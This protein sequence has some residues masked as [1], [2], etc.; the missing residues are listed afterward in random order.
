[1]AGGAV[2]TWTPERSAAGDRSPW[3]I[4]SIVSLATFME[5]LDT[6]IAN[7]AL[8][9]IA[10]GLSASYDEATWVVTSYLI[11]NAIAV[12]ISGWLS[13]VVG[14]KRFYM[15]SVIIFTFA[16][17]LCGIAPTLPFLIVARILQGLG[18][19]GL[20]PSEQSILTQTFPPAQRGQAYALY[21]L[22]VI[23]AP[24]LGPTLGGLITDN[25]G[26]HAIFLINIP[27][28]L[29]SLALVQ[30]FVVDP[31]KLEEERQ[32]RLKGGLRVDV[33]GIV[34]L[35]LWL[36]CQEFVLDRGQRLDW[37]D[38]PVI[39][40]AL[41]VSSCAAVGLWLWEWNHKDPVFDVRLLMHRSYAIAIAVMMVTGLV[42]FGILQVIP[43]FLQ[44]GLGYTASNAGKAM[45]LGGLVTVLMMSPAGML[46]SKVQPK[47]LI[48]FGLASEAIGLYMFTG[49]N[50]E[51]SFWWM[52]I[53]RAMLAIGTP[54]LFIPINTVAYADVPPQKTADASAQINLARYLGG[55]VTIAA[56]QAMLERRSQFHQ[57]RLVETLT[58]GD[59]NYLAWANGLAQAFGP[60]VSSSETSLAAI[61]Q[62]VVHQAQLLAFVDIFW[63]LSIVVTATIPL[64]LFMKKVRLHW[65]A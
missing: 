13:N 7:V 55:S 49:L 2:G 51:V 46:S 12:P 6:A 48:I 30:S 37:L 60:A 10:G 36:G 63:V 1:M 65:G 29:L 43:Q 47:Y 23:A 32:A 64:I 19:G 21:G 22:T 31:P 58:P 35:I 61:Y 33:P 14:R 4:V 15:L 16:S 34:L 24:I 45:T 17:F 28:G 56:V 50:G 62:S 26:W 9:H 52:A 54:F 44:I 53:M 40:A 8:D 27:V 57:A 25:I 3:L 41:G 38:S 18:G 20:A 59:A 39:C 5:V 42:V 11:A